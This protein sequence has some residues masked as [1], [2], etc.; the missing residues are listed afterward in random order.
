VQKDTRKRADACHQRYRTDHGGRI[1]G[2]GRRRKA[3]RIAKTDSKVGGALVKGE[4]L[5]KAQGADDH[6]QKGTKQAKG[7]VV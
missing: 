1:S 6:Q 7:G 5:W 4:Q 3:F 2:R